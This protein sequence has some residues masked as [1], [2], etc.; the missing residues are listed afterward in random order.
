MI[1][2]MT[3]IQIAAPLA[4][5][6]ALLLW[7]Q[8]REVLHINHEAELAN[9][10]FASTT[11]F[12]LAQLQLTLDFIT[13][14]RR[15]LRL[16]P[17]KNWRDIFITK[18]VG[19]VAS[20]H[21]TLQE[22]PIKEITAGAHRLNHALTELQH[23]EQ[24]VTQEL[25]AYEPWA[26]LALTGQTKPSVVAH[27]LI[28]YTSRHEASVLNGLRAI[29]TS[30]YQVVQ[31]VQRGKIEVIYM[32][33]MVHPADG[34]ALEAVLVAHNT[35]S[36]RLALDLGQSIADHIR[37]LRDQQTQLARNYRQTLDHAK[38]LLGQETPLKFAYDALL[39]LLEREHLS[40]RIRTLPHLFII[41][42]WIPTALLPVFARELEHRFPATALVEIAADPVEKKPVTL[43]NN[44][45]ITPFE[46][47]TNMY[48]KP[49]YHELDPSGP[50]ALFFL[51]SFGLA[52]TDAGYGLVMMIG[53][54]IAAK[55]FRLKKSLKKMIHLLFL[56]GAMTVI[57]GALTGGWFGVTVET[58]PDSAVKQMLLTVKIVDPLAQPMTLLA[59]ALSVGV[60]QL[61]FAWVVKAVYLWRNHQRLPAILDNL[62]WLFIVIAMMVWGATKT[63]LVSAAWTKPALWAVWLAIAIII[64]T[65]GRTNKNPFLKVGGGVLSLFGLMS[66]VSDTLSYSRLLALGLATGII[67]FVVNLLA[68]MAAKQ[69]PLVGFIVAI[70]VLITG[71]SFNL[72]INALGAFIHSSRLQFVEFFPK[73]L[74][75]GG[76]PY[77]PFGRVGRYVDNPNE[78]S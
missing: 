31:R 73:L 49:G 51:V 30:V 75:G 70:G 11:A 78:F 52:L 63:A 71:H 16:L 60:I 55:F 45:L 76:L 61:L 6:D 39:H 27:Y 42:G 50:L 9:E 43:L 37:A 7:L 44:A 15:E 14:W 33:I 47:L 41:S 10:A 17:K 34:P 58:L 38:P 19:S 12:D 65:Q 22:L 35:L 67:A 32:E 48:G 23:A 36:M 2:P 1:A 69:V 64:L 26:D 53:T 40:T 68:D 56:A 66:F 28:T 54:F 24:A 46:T 5:R 3:K 25:A 18:P 4:E 8:D 20:L 74:E 62:P 21:Q 29:A 57:L 59:V 72:A 13:T 77:K